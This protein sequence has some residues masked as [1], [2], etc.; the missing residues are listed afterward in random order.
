ML[1]QSGNGI[2]APVEVGVADNFNSSIFRP[3]VSMDNVVAA[4]DS[5]VNIV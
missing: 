3:S 2:E 1:H 5:P 4:R